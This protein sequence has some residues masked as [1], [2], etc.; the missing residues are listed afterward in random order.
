MRQPIA[1]ALFVFLAA[2]CQSLIASSE[3]LPDDAFAKI[4]LQFET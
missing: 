2:A 3:P 4:A 1:L